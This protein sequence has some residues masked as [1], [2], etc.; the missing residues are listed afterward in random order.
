MGL[1]SSPSGNKVC[2]FILPISDWYNQTLHKNVCVLVGSITSNIVL[3]LH[4][5]YEGFFPPDCYKNITKP[6]SHMAAQDFN[7]TEI[8]NEMANPYMNSLLLS[9]TRRKLRSIWLRY[10]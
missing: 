5:I 3:V 2:S 4:C 10:F 7:I 6:L 9:Y 1:H 8:I